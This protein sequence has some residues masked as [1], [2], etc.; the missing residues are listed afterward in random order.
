VAQRL[1]REA[2]SIAGTL[3]ERYL[4]EKRG[5]QISA[6]AVDHVLRWH[7]GV[8]AIIGLMTDAGSGGP[9]GVHRTFLD[10]DGSKIE[11]KMLGRQ[12]VV[13]LGVMAA[14]IQSRNAGQPAALERK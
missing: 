8:R 7:G 11:R 13:R 14:H 4:A 12:G 10:A 6:L 1:W 5:L 2:R 3:G 9:L